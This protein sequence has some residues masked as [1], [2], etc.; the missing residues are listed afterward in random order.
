MMCVFCFSGCAL[1]VDTTTRDIQESPLNLATGPL[2]LPVPPLH[3]F[4]AEAAAKSRA[5]TVGLS[6]T[7]EAASAGPIKMTD[8]DEDYD[9]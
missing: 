1:L 6:P 5:V 9:A 7:F 3:Y 2:S 4:S 8:I